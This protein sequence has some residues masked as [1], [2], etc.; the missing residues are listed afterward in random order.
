M[1]AGSGIIAA[2]RN[3]LP[4]RVLALTATILAMLVLF[5]YQS[6]YFLTAD[7]VANI[8]SQLPEVGL[9]SLSLTFIIISGAMDLSAGS[10]I[11]LAAAAL[12]LSYLAGLTILA[13]ALLAI[14]IVTACCC[15]AGFLL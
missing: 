7:N 8:A 5:N 13:T 2:L 11:W 14:F 12:G 15:R 4:I 9:I 6:P 10:I 3:A 1:T